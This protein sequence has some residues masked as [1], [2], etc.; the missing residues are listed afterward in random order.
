MP[1]AKEEDSEELAKISI[2]AVM[3]EIEQGAQIYSEISATFIQNFT[4]YDMTLY[5][6]TNELTIDIPPA[7]ELTTEKFREIMIE[8]AM[9][10][11]RAS[12]FYSASSIIHDAIQG[13]NAIKKSDVINAIVNNFAARGARRPGQQ[14]IDK[15][16]ESY[17]SSTISSK[18]AAKLVK[19]FWRQRL[20]TLEEVKKIMEQ[21]A[22]SIHVEMKWT[23]Q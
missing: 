2:G 23:A 1:E 15:M 12:N 5:E 19:Q 20:D 9:K 4:F 18:V 6:W 8:L 14:V 3:S 22:M 11:Q 10:T 16:A 17:L 13:G 7:K 21:I